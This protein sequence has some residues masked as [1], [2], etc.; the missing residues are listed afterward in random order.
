MRN[1]IK[2]IVYQIWQNDD[3]F[4]SIDE[5]IE[6]FIDASNGENQEFVN[7]IIEQL[8]EDGWDKEQ[9][10]YYGPFYFDCIIAEYA[11]EI[12]DKIY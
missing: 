5:K 3:L 11:E 2:D 12:L 9:I 6:V 8:L 7:N 10:D 4:E 1:S